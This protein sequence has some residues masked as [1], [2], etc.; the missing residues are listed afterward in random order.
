MVQTLS[1]GNN[2]KEMPPVDLLVIDEAHHA[3]APS[4]KN[5]LE[6]ARKVNPELKILGVT[7][8][9]ERGDK[10]SLGE[11]FN[12]CCD[13]IK[14]GEL[15]LSG[16]LIRPITFVIDMGN[17]LMTMFAELAGI[18]P[19]DQIEGMLATQMIATHHATMDC[20]RI[21]A[22]NGQLD[23]I[24]QML[25]YANKLSRTFTMQMEALSRYRGKGGQKMTVEHVHINSGGQAIIGNVTKNTPKIE[26]GQNRGKSNKMNNNPVPIKQDN[27]C[28][29]RTCKG[30][31]AF[32]QARKVTGKKRCRECTEELVM[33]RQKVTRTHLS[34]EDIAGK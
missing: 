30:K 3:T 8:T 33:V 34:T 1:R 7:A 20:F 9:P 18:E 15:I 16:N 2:L 10:S 5:I 11:V 17:T 27:K 13:Q 24:N 25:C 21:V 28:L 31:S 26:R 4:Y 29:A 14:I 23:I 19:K 6:Y 22:Q 32:Y 12:N